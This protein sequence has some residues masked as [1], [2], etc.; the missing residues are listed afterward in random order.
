[1]WSIKEAKT[2]QYYLTALRSNKQIS[3]KFSVF[4]LEI[5]TVSKKWEEN[6]NPLLSS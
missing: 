2:F 1:M 3:K 5:L 4:L 6:T